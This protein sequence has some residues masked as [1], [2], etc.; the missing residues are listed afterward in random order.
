M[1]H[2]ND[3]T[4]EGD[5]GLL[6]QPKRTQIEIVCWLIQHENIASALEYLRKEYSAAFA[7]TEKL[8]FRVDS[9]FRKKE[10]SQ[11]SSQGDALIAKPH[12]FATLTDF[13][14]NGFMIVQKHSTLIYL[15]DLGPRADLYLTGRGL[16]LAIR[17]Q[18]LRAIRYRG[19]STLRPD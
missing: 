3:A 13:F 18:E 9:V 17:S 8:N 7:A 19:Q 11:I 6:Q 16:Q 12:I 15:I 1:A 5:E 4:I 14:P 2:D 10:S